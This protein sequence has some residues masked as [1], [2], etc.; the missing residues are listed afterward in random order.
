MSQPERFVAVGAIVKPHGVRG[1][2]RVKL[3]NA[4][5]DV[6]LEIAQVRLEREGAAATE[7]TIRT[8]RPAAGGFL[9]V[10]FDGIADCN[11]AEKLRGGVINVPR[12]ALPPPDPGEFYV[13]DV[14]GARVLFSDGTEAG[15][16]VDFHSFPTTDV[17]VVEHEGRRFDV[18]LVDDFVESVDVVEA[19]V[20]VRSLDGLEST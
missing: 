11:A 13:C 14:L 20:V 3:F 6:L 7:L 12:D 1:E 9:L 4:D 15:R 18:P 5:S 16:I 17:L 2:V 8:A 10:A 19:R